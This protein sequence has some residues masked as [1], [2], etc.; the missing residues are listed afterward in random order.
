MKRLAALAWALCLPAAPAWAQE[1]DAKVAVYAFGSARYARDVTRA[2]H[3]ESLDQPRLAR[4]NGRFK[5][6]RRALVARFG[7][8]FPAEDPAPMPIAPRPCDPLLLAAYAAQV[9]QLEQAAKAP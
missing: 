8:H 7:E 9:S 5:A 2:A 1:A 6:A 3:C 4:I